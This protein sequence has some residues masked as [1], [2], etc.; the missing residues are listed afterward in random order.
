MGAGE[1]SV[2][3]QRD[4]QQQRG[5]GPARAQGMPLSAS[6]E[7]TR[8]SQW[9]G[10]RGHM[11]LWDARS[12]YQ[13]DDSGPDPDADDHPG[14]F[15]AEILEGAYEWGGQTTGPHSGDLMD[16]WEMLRRSRPS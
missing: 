11:R 9:P 15:R 10:Q 8:E 2:R 5:D 13:Y 12:G 7:A 14:I 6:S 1:Q 4:G 3:E 16:G